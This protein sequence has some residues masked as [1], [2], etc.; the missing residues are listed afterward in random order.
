MRFRIGNIHPTADKIHRRAGGGGRG[1][2][3]IILPSVVPF[4]VSNNIAVNSVDGGD[5]IFKMKKQGQSAVTF[6]AGGGKSA[7]NHSFVAGYIGSVF[8]TG[9]DGGTCSAPGTGSLAYSMEYMANGGR[10]GD[11]GDAAD[12]ADGNM[13]TVT[14]G[15]WGAGTVP[16]TPGKGGKNTLYNRL[17][18]LQ[19]SAGGGGGGGC[20][21]FSIVGGSSVG[22]D[23]ASL[24]TKATTAR[25]GGGGGGGCGA[26]LDEEEENRN[27]SRKSNGA[28]GYVYMKIVGRIP[29]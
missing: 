12:G 14:Q 15:G 29:Q 27:Q 28:P 4:N 13:P 10:G 20:A 23:G 2:S 7:G 25:Y 6:R 22:G 17:L 24:N 21:A 5:T 11:G 16:W 18:F 1:P 9:R 3:V 26:N 19:A 8:K